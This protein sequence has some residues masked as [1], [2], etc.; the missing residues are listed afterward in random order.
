MFI[1]SPFWCHRPSAWPVRVGPCDSSRSGPS[2]S[3]L[4][5]RF[6]SS[7]GLQRETPID[8]AE[9]G[10]IAGDPDAYPEG[11]VNVSSF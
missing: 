2:G 8:A 7:P 6:P 1:S 3:R 11:I 5:S 4:G 9:P 10:P